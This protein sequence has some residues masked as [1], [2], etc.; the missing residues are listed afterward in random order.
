MRPLTITAM[1]A[2]LAPIKN[3]E[4]NSESASN[5]A[6]VITPSV[7]K[8]CLFNT[9]NGIFMRVTKLKQEM[10]TLNLYKQVYST[11]LS[12]TK[13]LSF[14]H[15]DGNFELICQKYLLNSNTVLP[16]ALQK[17]PQL[18]KWLL[19][20]G[21]YS[22]SWLSPGLASLYQNTSWFNVKQEL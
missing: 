12:K 21:W 17:P 1:N 2:E 3:G 6:S 14:I 5:I 7:I 11:S 4:Q 8:K 9:K 22:G 16:F 20:Q 18:M 19:G 13:T 10:K 15:I